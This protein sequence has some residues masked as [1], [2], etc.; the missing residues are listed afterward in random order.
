MPC[1]AQHWGDAP[2][3]RG[4]GCAQARALRRTYTEQQVSVKVR[5]GASRQGRCGARMLSSITICTSF[6][7][8]VAMASTHTVT[9]N[10][11]SPL[12]QGSLQSTA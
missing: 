11:S 10:A 5:I 2:H 12:S 3:T 6:S 8:R 9:W 4:P 7:F 1:H